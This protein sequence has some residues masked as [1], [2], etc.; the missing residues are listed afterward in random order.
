MFVVLAWFSVS[1]YFGAILDFS[2]ECELYK[3]NEQKIK[4][5]KK[6]KEMRKKKKKRMK[7]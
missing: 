6:K 2:N 4:E 5:K 7:K 3:K 1:Q